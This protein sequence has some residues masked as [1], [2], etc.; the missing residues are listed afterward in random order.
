M[1]SPVLKSKMRMHLTPPL[2]GRL[3]HLSKFPLG[4]VG[5]NLASTINQRK[6]KLF[7]ITMMSVIWIYMINDCYSI[8]CPNRTIRI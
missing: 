8:N 2:G 5:T 1:H 4:G 3:R 6:P 7:Q